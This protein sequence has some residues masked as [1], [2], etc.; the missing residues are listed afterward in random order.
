MKSKQDR[1]CEL[2]VYL[3]TLES[4][5]EWCADALDWMQHENTCLAI[6]ETQQ[7]ISDLS[8]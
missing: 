8:S 6:Y 2:R 3:K 4:F 1:I 5:K 7:E